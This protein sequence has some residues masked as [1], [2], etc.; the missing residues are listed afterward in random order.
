MPTLAFEDG[1][2]GLPVDWRRCRSTACGDGP[3]EGAVR[4][5]DADLPVT[6]FVHVV[7]RRPQGALL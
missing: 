4:R 1:S 6:A 3:G 2:H 7:D 5:S